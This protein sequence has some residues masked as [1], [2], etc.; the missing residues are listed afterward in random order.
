M[1]GGHISLFVL[2]S[3]VIN[4]HVDAFVPPKIRGRRISRGDDDAP[5]KKVVRQMFS[6]IVEEMG[7]VVSLTT[8]PALTLWDGS[9][10]E[11]TELVVRSPSGV[12]L[13]G[14]YEGASIAINGVCTTVVVFD[15]HTFK[16]GLA[17]ETLRRSNLGELSSG[18]PVNLERSLPADGRNSGHFVQ[19]HVD[20]TGTILS[21]EFE[22]ES[23]WIK[24][25]APKELMRF[26]V[27]KGF[28]AVDGTSLTVCDVNHS[29][30]WFTFMLVAFSQQKIVVPLKDVGATVNL[31]ADVFGKYVERSVSALVD[32]VDVLE[33]QVQALIAAAGETSK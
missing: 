29:E 25:G 13:E 20:C 15:E 2:A 16:V 27:P 8:N 12:I 5:R 19:G 1:T 9:V 10:G 7:E 18:R 28:I 24:V 22:G 3:L 11:G 33:K 23:L 26:V 17:P 32:R 31:E 14:S 21:K 30:G 4:A 6:G